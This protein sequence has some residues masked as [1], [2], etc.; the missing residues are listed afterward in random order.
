MNLGISVKL[1]SFFQ[2]DFVIDVCIIIKQR[3]SNYEKV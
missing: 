1:I 2:L 3:R